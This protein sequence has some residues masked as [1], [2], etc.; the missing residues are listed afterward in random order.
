MADYRY[1]NTNFKRTALSDYFSIVGASSTRNTTTKD[2]NSDASLCQ[3]FPAGANQTWAA[4]VQIALK[5]GS[6]AWRKSSVS[7]RLYLTAN[8]AAILG[9]F[10]N[11]SAAL[12][13]TTAGN[14]YINGADS[15]INV[16]LNTW[17]TIE[18]IADDD[19]R[20]LGSASQLVRLDGG[21]AYQGNTA[22]SPG[23]PTAVSF[24]ST[25][26][27]QTGPATTY[28][29]NHVA[30][31]YSNDTNNKAPWLNAAKVEQNDRVPTA[32]GSNNDFTGYSDTT[33]KYA[34]ADESPSNTTDYNYG[35]AAG[36][37]KKQG[38]TYTAVTYGTTPRGFTVFNLFKGETGKNAPAGTVFNLVRDN[39]VDY[40]EQSALVIS[41]TAYQ[42]STL[43]YPGRP[44]DNSALSSATLDA[45]EGGASAVITST[46]G[47]PDTTMPTA[48]GATYDGVWTLTGGTAGSAFTT[49]NS[50]SDDSYTTYISATTAG[51]KQGLKFNWTP[52]QTGAV[53]TSFRLYLKA[54]SKDANSVTVNIGVRIGT[55]DYPSDQ[56]LTVTASNSA[57]GNATWSGS[58]NNPATGVPFTVAEFNSVEFYLNVTTCTGTGVDVDWFWAAPSFTY[59][60]AQLYNAASFMVVNEGDAPTDNGAIPGTGT[61]TQPLL[62][63]MGVG[64]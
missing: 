15:G 36:L 52:S 51:Q 39:S 55:T 58:T 64:T 28:Y 49:V 6:P 17:H 4:N 5:S 53:L 62:T 43:G 48:D 21:T 59:T 35:G 27:K 44:A 1:F 50:A 16:S 10:T 14:L 29:I 18:Y 34:N 3:T 8:P 2:A 46:A 40:T 45:M 61:V 24:G 47:G 12:S 37:T 20:G 13:L 30:F 41:S 25:G 22:G 63:L 26:T 9:I 57:F 33:N 32:N 38:Y 42:A 60:S 11:G 19:W 56:S 54:R 7:F 31:W 23:P